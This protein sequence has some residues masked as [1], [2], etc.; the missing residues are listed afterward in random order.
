LV[1]EFP[2]ATT[3]GNAVV[4]EVPDDGRTVDL[5]LPGEITDTGPSDVGGH[6]LEDLLGFQP[7]LNLQGP[8]WR[9]LF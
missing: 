3:P 6:Q 8:W 1:G 2:L 5:E 9:W 7:V 4:F